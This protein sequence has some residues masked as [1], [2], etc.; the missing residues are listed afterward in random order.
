MDNQRNIIL[1]IVLCLALLLGF[2]LVV[3]KLYQAPPPSK[4]VVAQA[5]TAAPH[6]APKR[7]R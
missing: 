4:H 3:G 2:D 1:A 6:T 7:T 5:E